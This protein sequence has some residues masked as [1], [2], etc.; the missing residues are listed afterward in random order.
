MTGAMVHRLPRVESTMETAHHLAQEGAAHGTAVVAT[1]QTGGRGQR[2][3]AWSS[4]PGG[5][6]LSV[7]GRPEATEGI[8]ALSLQV[9]LALAAA[10]EEA[11]PGLPPLG[12]KW[13][14]DLILDGR[15]VGGILTEARWSDGRCLW[16]V[17]GVGINVTNPL[18][19]GT[20]PPATRLADHVPGVRVDG[21]VAVAVAAVTAA[22]ATPGVLG[23]TQVAAFARR[24][25]LRGRAIEAPVPGVAD[26][27]TATGALRVRAPDGAIHHCVAGVVP[28]GA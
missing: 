7:V 13:P 8:G 20:T 11:C 10:M 22:L 6:W 12:I 25:V 24:D 21:L 16:V 2:G 4:P 18:P 15:K 19:E 3:R 27:I 28:V 1:E 23:A 9:G 5:L 17:V 26:G 14:N